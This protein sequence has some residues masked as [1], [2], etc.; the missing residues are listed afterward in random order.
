MKLM[1]A[2]MLVSMTGMVGWNHPD[3][4]PQNEKKIYLDDNAIVYTGKIDRVGFR[5]LKELY[6]ESEIKPNVLRISSEQGVA[7]TGIVMGEWLHRNNFDVEVNDHCYLTCADYILPAGNNK[8]IGEQALIKWQGGWAL[9]GNNKEKIINKN[10]A[11]ILK[12]Y[13]EK[14]RQLSA[15]KKSKIE[16][17]IKKQI[18]TQFSDFTTDNRAYYQLLGVDELISDYGFLQ[19]S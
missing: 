15:K 5:Q 16:A 18:L 4:L 10:T 1:T 2:V 19:Q 13:K 9:F 3:E 14:N 11:L 6:R 8:F 7:E 12:S 17:S